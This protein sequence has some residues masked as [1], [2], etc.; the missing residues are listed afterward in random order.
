MKTSKKTLSTSLTIK[1]KNIVSF[2]K[3]TQ[4][5]KE[6]YKLK[7][8]NFSISNNGD[9]FIKKPILEETKIAYINPIKIGKLDSVLDKVESK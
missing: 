5:K 1:S 3:N 4:K 2:S 6:P 7:G 8:P 9:V